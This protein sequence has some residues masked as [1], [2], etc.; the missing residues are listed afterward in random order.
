MERVLSL[1]ADSDPFLFFRLFSC[2]FIVSASSPMVKSPR[3]RVCVEGELGTD[4]LAVG[5]LS[6]EGIFIARLP[7]TGLGPT[8]D[9]GETFFSR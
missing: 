9:E 5:M 8:L 4:R 2:S 3:V 7:T 6:W 1:P